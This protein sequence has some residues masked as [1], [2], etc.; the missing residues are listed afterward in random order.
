MKTIPLLLTGCLLCSYTSAARAL[1]TVPGG[2]ASDPVAAP[3]PEGIVDDSLPG[4]TWAVDKEI[5]DPMLRG[6]SAHAL[7]A[8]YGG[9]YT[10]TGTGVDVY[11][12]KEPAVTVD[13]RVHKKGELSISIDG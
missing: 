7:P 12:I 5:A 1:N 11:T 8:G 13:D 2:H 9:T 10:F 6:G 4:W 3:S